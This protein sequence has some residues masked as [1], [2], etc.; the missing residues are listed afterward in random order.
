M[1]T[2][3]HAAIAILNRRGRQVRDAPR[4]DPDRIDRHVTAQLD[5]DLVA[6]AVPRLLDDGRCGAAKGRVRGEVVLVVRRRSQQGRPR[7][8][9]DVAP[10]GEVD[11]WGADGG[12][13]APAVVEV[14]GLV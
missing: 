11:F 9:G 2:P 8:V 12:D 10:A 4:D 5:V 13:W 7:R 14:P 3:K 1:N 6:A